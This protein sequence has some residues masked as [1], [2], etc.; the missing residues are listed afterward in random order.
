MQR[1]IEHGDLQLNRLSQE[2]KLEALMAARAKLSLED[3]VCI[4]T[5]AD[6]LILTIKSVHPGVQFS[7][8]NALELIAMLGIFFNKRRIS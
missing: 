3:A 2:D 4:D 1:S 6:N 8:S 5:L 7:R